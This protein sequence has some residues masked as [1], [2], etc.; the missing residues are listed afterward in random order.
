MGKKNGSFQATVLTHL[1]YIRKKQDEHDTKIGLIFDKLDH[2][3]ASCSKRF[4]CIEKDVDTTKGFAKGALTVG[5]IGGA[6]G[7]ISIL[8]RIFGMK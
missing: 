4:N 5:G 6:G 2:Q 8:L 7:F 1:D 3:V